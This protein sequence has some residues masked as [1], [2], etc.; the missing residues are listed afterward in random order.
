MLAWLLGE[1]AGDEVRRLLAAAEVVITSE[2]TLVECDRVLIR[3]AALKELAEGEAADRRAQLIEAAATW[4]VLGLSRE[5]TER[6][7]QLF[8]V[9]PVRTLDGI[10]LAS[11]LI[12]RS[13]V[14]ELQMLS[15]DERIRTNARAMSVPLQPP[16]E[17]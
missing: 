11:A 6:V 9:E 5:V 7:R 8:P 2:L 1:P 3:A 14:T 17:A 13:A 4:H 10:H 16:V 12:S 15:L